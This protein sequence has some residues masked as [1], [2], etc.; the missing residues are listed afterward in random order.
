M[1][2]DIKNIDQN[3]EASNRK[4]SAKKKFFLFLLK[5]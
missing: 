1:Y 4:N 2:N 3:K 5:S